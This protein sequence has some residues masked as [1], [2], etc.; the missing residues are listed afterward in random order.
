MAGVRLLLLLPLLAAGCAHPEARPADE[1]RAPVRAV[2]DWRRVATPS[3]R[4]R[5]RNWRAAWLRGLAEAR[6][7]AAAEVA[8]EGA[9]LDPD[10]ALAHAAL[11]PGEYRCRLLKLG[12][13]L[14]F[15]PYP[16][17]RCRV[18]REGDAVRLT[19]L[20]GSQRQVGLVFPHDDR[21]Q[22]FLGTLLLSDETRAIDYGRDADRDVAG[23]VER[24]GERRWRVA[25]PSPRFESVMD[26]MELVPA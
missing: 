17:F 10:A 7:G 26:V 16:Y 8:R 12:G 20:T 18:H 21:R 3:D 13:L 4:E 24:V 22:A 2:A 5:L 11:P 19:K 1:V 6:R 9:V 23:W 25:F 15:T 14:P